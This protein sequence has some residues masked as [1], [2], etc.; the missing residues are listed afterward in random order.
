MSGAEGRW[1]PFGGAPQ[2][3][4][5]MKTSN[6]QCYICGELIARGTR[7]YRAKPVE[8]SGLGPTHLNAKLYPGYGGKASLSLTWRHSSC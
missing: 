1:S 7:V 5:V 4:E 3:G 6:R 2:G 8:S